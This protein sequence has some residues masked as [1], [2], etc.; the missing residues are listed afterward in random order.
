MNR[1]GEI[2]IPFTAMSRPALIE[3]CTDL[4]EELERVRGT[5]TDESDRVSSLRHKNSKLIR[6]QKKAKGKI[7]KLAKKFIRESAVRSVIGNVVAL[8]I[9][10]PASLQDGSFSVYLVLNGFCS[11]VLI[12]LQ[13]YLQK[14]NEEI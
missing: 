1:R 13:T 8:G 4:T 10:I 5:L 9:T 11:A 6:V 2:N 7:D 12:P 3:K 14:R